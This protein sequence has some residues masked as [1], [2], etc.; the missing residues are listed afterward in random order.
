[1]RRTVLAIAFAVQGCF[2]GATPMQRVSDAARDANLATRFG[3][4][5]IATRHVDAA[6]QN[7]FLLRRAQWGKSIR[8]LDLELAGIHLTDEDH[9]TVTVDVSWSS[10]TDSL[11]RSTKLTQEWQ[12]ERKGWKLVRERRLSGDVGLF[13]EPLPLLEPPHPD[14]HR[15]SRTIGAR[16]PNDQT[17]ND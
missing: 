2:A 5:E 16:P 4:V 3:Q 13:G 12:N 1:M 10:V 6:V 11:V 17:T 9:A 14:V 7:D 8:V 15:P